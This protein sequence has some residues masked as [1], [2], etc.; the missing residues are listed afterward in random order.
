MTDWTDGKAL[1]REFRLA[2]ERAQVAGLVIRGALLDVFQHDL[3]SP[4]LDLELTIAR[5]FDFRDGQDT[6]RLRAHAE[7]RFAELHDYMG[8]AFWI[9]QGGYR[10]ST[11]PLDECL[12]TAAFAEHYPTTHR[13]AH[14]PPIVTL[15]VS[16]PEG[17]RRAVHS[18]VLLPVAKLALLSR[19]A[20][21]VTLQVRDQP[22]L[23]LFELT[24]I[25]GA[26]DD[27]RTF[28]EGDQ[29]AQR[30]TA[31]LAMALAWAVDVLGGQVSEN[32]RSGAGP[33]TIV[34]P[35]NCVLL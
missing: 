35:R 12:C 10:P 3:R 34:L 7:K 2:E 26:C 8:L 6:P 22:S 19:E 9:T 33:I 20:S 27:D 30:R 5:I 4:L 15:H 11:L 21:T 13:R 1:E 14:P 23:A 29:Y 25:P 31:G 17:S 16:P 32:Y 28:D 24:V 18:G